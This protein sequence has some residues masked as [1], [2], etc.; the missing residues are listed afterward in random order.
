VA[1]HGGCLAFTKKLT[2]V[3]KKLKEKGE[4]FEVVFIS[5]DDKEEEFKDNF[6]TMPWLALPFQDKNCARLVRYFE[7]RALPTLVAIG[8]DG[9]TLDL[10][11]AESIEE[12]GEE[13]YP[14]TPEQF[15]K[16]AEIEKAKHESQSL[17][18]I[19]VSAEKDYCISK[20][21]SQVMI[22][23]SP[24]ENWIKSI[25]EF[26]FPNHKFYCFPF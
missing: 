11:V 25:L 18:S 21:G 6:G 26:K 14:F 7:L 2:E 1:S 8:P 5:L 23:I 3:Y 9:K 24:L 22:A 4:N 13:A 17:E 20:D 10:N 15:A 19:L 16:L 12:H